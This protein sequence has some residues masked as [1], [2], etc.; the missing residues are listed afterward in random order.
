MVQGMAA[1][2]YL[3]RLAAPALSVLMR[4]PSSKGGLPGLGHQ[5]V[6]GILTR[7][8]AQLGFYCGGDGPAAF[9]RVL[10]VLL[11]GSVVLFPA[12]EGLVAEETD[13]VVGVAGQRLEE[14]ASIG[15]LQT[16]DTT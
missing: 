4:P 8:I 10:Q 13:D 12:V 6:P 5:R 15:H 3:L 11:E 16:I 2:S 1:P 9:G 7:I 14:E